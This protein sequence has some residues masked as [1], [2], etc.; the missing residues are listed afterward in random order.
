[1]SV[2]QAN[3]FRRLISLAWCAVLVYALLPAMGAGCALAHADQVQ[4]H[5]GDDGSS[6]QNAGCAWA[7]PATVDAAVAS[8]LGPTVTELIVGPA[9]FSTHRLVSSARSFSDRTRAPPIPLLV[10]L[11]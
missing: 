7:C 1:M 3:R 6:P 8:G 4:H 9:E 10:S 11:R 2:T 5:H